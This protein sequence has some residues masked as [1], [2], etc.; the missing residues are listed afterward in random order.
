MTAADRNRVRTAIDAHQRALIAADGRGLR[1]C[2]GCGTPLDNYTD[3]CKSCWTRRRNHN[4]RGDP[5]YLAAQRE[6]QRRTR[7]SRAKTACTT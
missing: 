5:A 4:R 1:R 3:G 2:H 7:K 6:R